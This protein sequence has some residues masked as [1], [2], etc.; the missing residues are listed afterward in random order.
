MLSTCVTQEYAVLDNVLR[1]GEL[2]NVRLC[3][4]WSGFSYAVLWVTSVALIPFPRDSLT[5]DCAF[6]CVML[7][8]FTVVCM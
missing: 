5:L 4:R 3:L 2:C 7:G 6:D 1:I 8:S